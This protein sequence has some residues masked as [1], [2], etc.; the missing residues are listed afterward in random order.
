MQCRASLVLIITLF[1]TPSLF[2]QVPQQIKDQ[3]G[4]P[5]WNALFFDHLNNLDT[6]EEMQL[7][8][9][10]LIKADPLKQEKLPLRI[11]Y[12]L[13]GEQAYQSR[14]WA[15]ARHYWEF[16]ARES[17]QAGLFYRRLAEL[18]LRQGYYQ[19]A[20]AW[21]YL[22]EVDPVAQLRELGAAYHGLVLWVQEDYEQ[23]RLLMD[24][25]T[26]TRPEEVPGPLFLMVRK[27]VTD[28]DAAEYQGLERLLQR[29]Y[30]ENPYGTNLD[31]RPLVRVLEVPEDSSQVLV[32]D[33]TRQEGAKDTGDQQVYQIAAYTNEDL[34]REKALE[35]RAGAIL[36]VWGRSWWLTAGMW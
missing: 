29:V 3:L 25:F 26:A 32:Q 14:E 9:G 13:Q 2:A 21:I 17:D 15:L 36:C 34:A 31:F 11:Y 24:Q 12:Y 28:K 5:G 22:M 30:P 1:I 16:G 27:M 18:E 7:F 4:K 19:D 8:L 23:A 10:D 33:P 6:W 35:Y 20:L